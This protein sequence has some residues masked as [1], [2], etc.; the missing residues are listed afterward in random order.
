MW[1]LT[2]LAQEAVNDVA[3]SDHPVAQLFERIDSGDAFVV[4][5]VSISCVT[6]VL[7]TLITSMA[8]LFRTLRFGRMRSQLIQSMLDRGLAP[9]EISQLVALTHVPDGKNCRT[10]EPAHVPSQ[11]V[12]SSGIPPAKPITAR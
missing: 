9:D 10:S 5:I 7:I 6:A 2:L 4:V 8:A 12:A 11:V 1:D 3:A